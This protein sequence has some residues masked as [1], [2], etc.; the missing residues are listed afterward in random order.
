MADAQFQS[1]ATTGLAKLNAMDEQSARA[2]LHSVCGSCKWV[3]QMLSLRPFADSGKLFAEADRVW[4]GLETKDWLEAFSHHPRIGERNLAQ[5]K[6]A[7]TA[8]QSSKEQ[9]GMAGASE[10]VRAEFA[11]GN[12]KYEKKFGHV[13]LICATGKTGQ[14][15]LDSLKKR[16]SN[17]GAT[18]LKNA[19][20]EQSRIVRIRL[21]K[22]VES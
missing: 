14:E 5:A 9:S 17:D 8:T 6:F 18:E 13:F 3:D 7:A 22:L 21:E 1:G 4:F 16:M 11:E 10:R 15:M 19:A 20:Q 2:A 12:E